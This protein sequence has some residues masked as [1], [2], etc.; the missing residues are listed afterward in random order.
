MAMESVS[1]F[2]DWPRLV[3]VK[4]AAQPELRFAPQCLE[5][6][7]TM[8]YVPEKSGNELVC[9]THS[10]RY[11]TCYVEW[12]NQFKC[13]RCAMAVRTRGRDGRKGGRIYG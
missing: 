9:Q 3:R 11:D 6:H 2:H 12:V 5:C 4:V 7:I 1:E 13:V 10:D 8:E